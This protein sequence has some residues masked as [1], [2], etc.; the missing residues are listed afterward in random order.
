MTLRAQHRLQTWE[1][2]CCKRVC[3]RAHQ[4]STVALEEIKTTQA[5]EVAAYPQETII[6]TLK[7]SG[8]NLST[9]ALLHQG[10]LRVFPTMRKEP[11]EQKDRKTN[12][13]FRRRQLTAKTSATETL[14][15]GLK[16][17]KHL[18]MSE[19]AVSGRMS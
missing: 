14:R 6:Q 3:R 15:N 12:S 10:L 1:E 7:Q 17:A 13:A 16:R 2:H 11:K 4:H 19:A 18:R 8:A 5:E 9:S